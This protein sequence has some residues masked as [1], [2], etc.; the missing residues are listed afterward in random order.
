[1]TCYGN[2]SLACT[3]VR[4]RLT[5]RIGFYKVI[6][7]SLFFEGIGFIFLQYLDPFYGF[8]GGIFALIFVADSYRPVIFVAS[9]TYS[10]PE[11]TTQSIALLRL[12]INLGFSI[13][14]LLGGLSIA[15]IT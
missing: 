10:K 13:G 8:C 1:M 7:R 6:T 5:D 9:D 14:P 15:H 3:L 11:N 2:G 4:G 12:A